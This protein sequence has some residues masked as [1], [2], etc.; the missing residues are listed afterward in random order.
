MYFRVNESILF[1]IFIIIRMKKYELMMII[2]PM[3]EK[4]ALETLLNDLRSELNDHGLSVTAETVWGTRDLAYKINKSTQGYY[5]IYQL[6]STDRLDTP[7]LNK[8]FGI[9]KGLWIH[10]LTH[11]T[12]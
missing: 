5:V 1:F 6:D 2:D 12:D 9:K 11:I 7:G 10:L 8:V 4:Q 3:L